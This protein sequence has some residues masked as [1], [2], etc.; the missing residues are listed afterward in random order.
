MVSITVPL[1]VHLTDEFHELIQ[2]YADKFGVSVQDILHH[3]FQKS[4][5]SGAIGCNEIL[6]VAELVDLSA[7]RRSRNG[8]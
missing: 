2:Q 1:T 7:F 4:L 6:P 5:P 3:I 8:R